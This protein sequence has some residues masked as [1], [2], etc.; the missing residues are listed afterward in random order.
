MGSEPYKPP[1]DRDDDVYDTLFVNVCMLGLT[2]HDRFQ[3]RVASELYLL[4]NTVVDG[5]HL[6]IRD[7]KL[8]ICFH[9]VT[10]T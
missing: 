10:L 2:Y 7:R 5:T 6:K 8:K 4:S 3:V 1:I 9:I